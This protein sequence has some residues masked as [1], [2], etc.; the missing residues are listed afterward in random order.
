LL[1]GLPLLW[2]LAWRSRA[3]LSSRRLMAATLLRSAAVAL[4][5][6]GLAGPVWLERSREISV[7]YA[8]D[9]S[10]SVSSAF[11]RQ[12][13][14]W[15]ADANI[16]FAPAQARF[17][18]FGDRARLVKAQQDVLSVPVADQQTLS[19]SDAIDQSA[20]DLEQALNTAVFGFAPHA[21]PR[22]VLV[23]D[24]NQTQGDLWRALP[25][26][27]AQGIRVFTIP[28]AVAVDNDAWVDAI[29]VPHSMRELEPVAVVV[30]VFSRTETDASLRVGEGDR[31]LATRALHLHPG[32]NEVS[33]T[34]RFP[35]KGSRVLTA[36]VQ[37]EGD[38]DA[39]N[40]TMSE[41]VW[42]G[43]RPR[44]L[45]VESAPE[46]AHYLADALRAHHIEVTVVTPDALRTDH[47]LLV[48]QDAVVLSDIEA[49]KIDAATAQAVEG[50]VRDRGQGL[51]FAAGERTYGRQGYSGSRVERLLPVRF[52]GKR[53][54][55]ELDLVLLLDRSH[56]MRGRKL[57]LAKSAALATLDLLDRHHRL[58]VV[59]FDS[60]P[61]E[62]VPLAAVG[63]KRRAEDLIASMTSSGQTNVYNALAHAQRLLAAST[64][65]TRHILL[66]SDGVTA[67]PPGTAVT[68]SSSE[69]AQELVRQARADTI[70]AV[71]GRFEREPQP[72][73]PAHAGGMEGL[74]AELATARITLST[75][76]IGEKPNLELMRALAEWGNGRN[77]VAA[78]D[79]EIPSLFV[80]ETR[81]LLGESIVEQPFQPE[82]SSRAESIAGVDFAAGPPLGGFV[83]TRSKPFSE[84][85]LQAPLDRP[86]LVQTHYGL[87]KTVAFLS[88]VK[89]RWSAQWL[90]WEGYGRFWAQVVR[91]TIPPPSGET[92]S[93]EVWRQ[94]REAMIE[95]R[96]LAPD[97]TYRNGLL[98]KVQVTAPDGNSSVL[99]LR[100]VAPGH[101]RTS[102]AIEPGR[103]AP[104]RFELLRGGGLSTRDL[105]QAGTRG[106][107]YPWPDEYRVLPPNVRVLQALSE[108]TGGVF[109]PRQ[110]D[111]FAD[112]G[113]GT[114]AARP[115]WPWLAA[116]ALLAFLL[117]VLVRRAPW[118]DAGWKPGAETTR[119]PTKTQQT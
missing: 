29:S 93:W 97:R 78:S 12:A 61:R 74:V 96:A 39:R 75:I 16:R 94:G 114:L 68:R 73:L 104:Y 30:Q 34:V 69:Q 57:E 28:A 24:G 4:V 83:V 87:G 70:R 117:D 88:D 10:R 7:V 15:I 62:V 32:E 35:R 99:G 101:Y 26:L 110:E 79:A 49:R 72:E 92:L 46:S 65:P 76:A 8:I 56:S 21:A 90:G 53:K 77:Y 102:A 119:S 113:N 59:A 112:R 52:Q 84:V 103:S 51:I 95:L 42:V 66:L 55:R 38:Q 71:G 43:P 14:D 9:V 41:S 23:T 107:I 82:V 91:D 63:S 118:L 81:R 18:V 50:F 100:Q 13:L 115:L 44:V 109:E 116:A 17:V 5:A 54:R 25:R 108:R 40:D 67:P 33:L 85:L 86:L 3:A 48:G 37:A 80:A 89:N 64:A 45:Y 11:L 6:L 22:L 20:T 98:P 2:L 31:G 27:Q 60:R 19:E 106:L 111:I 58:A 47:G 1:A 105:A 36:Q